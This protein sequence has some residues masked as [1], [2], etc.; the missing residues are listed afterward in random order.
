MKAAMTDMILGYT[1]TVILCVLTIVYIAFTKNFNKKTDRLFQAMA[2]V[3]L[4]L[5][6]ID[7]LKVLLA[8]YSLPFL[9]TLCHAVGY[10]LHVTLNYLILL[11]AA[12]R[13]NSS[14]KERI[15]QL[16]P[17]GVTVLCEAL[18]L[19]S[20]IV[21]SFGEDGGFVPGP[22]YAVPYLCDAVYLVWFFLLMNRN[23]IQRNVRALYAMLSLVLIV[24]GAAVAEFLTHFAG[25]RLAFCS[26]ALICYYLL[27][28]ISATSRDKLTGCFLRPQFYRDAKAR[29]ASALVSLDLNGLKALNDRYGHA[30]GDRALQALSSAVQTCLDKHTSF[31]RMGGDEFNVLCFHYSEKQLDDLVA[32]IRG[33]MAKTAYSWAIGAVWFGTGSSNIDDI[34]HR[35]DMR[36]IA[37]KKKMKAQQAP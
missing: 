4:L 11:I 15:A 28:H 18:A 12:R 5:A 16:L 1:P 33:A 20:P 8:F 31:Y 14:R 37:D 6:A 36:M 13:K 24:A 7:F 17:L 2:A 9:R 10:I 22:L 32:R 30:E 35:A 27:L 21:F 29:S 34:C 26:M 23:Y 19:F 3:I 25:V